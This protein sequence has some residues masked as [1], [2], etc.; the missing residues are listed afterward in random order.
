MEMRR[1]FHQENFST[2]FNMI[3][4]TT[5]EVSKKP[6]RSSSQD[7]AGHEDPDRERPMP[8]RPFPQR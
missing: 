2:H 5:R 3:R 8:D 4:R 6:I 1:A 7:I